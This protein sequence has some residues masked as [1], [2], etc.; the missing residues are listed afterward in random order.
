[1]YAWVH[2]PVETRHHEV[3]QRHGRTSR[4]TN[5]FILYRLAYSDRAKHW[6]AQNDHRTIFIL[7]GRSWK[8]EVPHIREKYKTLAVM[9]KRNHGRAHP[10]Y[11]FPPSIKKKRSQT[12]RARSQ[13]LMLRSEAFP[14]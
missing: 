1:M 14:K 11:R 8:M 2:R 7:T 4:P 10:G 3:L 5:P 6:L 9:E 12:A 13:K